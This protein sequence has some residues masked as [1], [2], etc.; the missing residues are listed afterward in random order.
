MKKKLVIFIL[1][2]FLIVNNSLSQEFSAYDL[3]KSCNN[4]KTWIDGNF[5]DPVDPQILF[6][7]GKCQGIMETTGKV[8]LTLCIERKRNANI[9]KQLTANLEGVKTITL[10]KEYVSRASKVT[11]LQKYNAQELLSVILSKRWPCR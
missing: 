7:M 11:N 4:Y 6:N 3:L 1:P 9:N 5:E 10:V 8:M 2:I